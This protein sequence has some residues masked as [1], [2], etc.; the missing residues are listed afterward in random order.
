VQQAADFYRPWLIEGRDW[1]SSTQTTALT[2]ASADERLGAFSADTVGVTLGWPLARDS[3]LTLRAE[4][5]RQ[6]QD[7]PSGAPGVLA[8]LAPAPDLKAT[9]LTVGWSFRW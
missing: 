1:N 4:T 9:M 6:R 2:A 3:L 7:A 8:T 5:Y